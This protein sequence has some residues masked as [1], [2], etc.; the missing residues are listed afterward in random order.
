MIVYEAIQTS[1]NERDL[2]TNPIMIPT[3][4]CKVCDGGELKPASVYKTSKLLA[5]MGYLLMIPSALIL[6]FLTLI[7]IVGIVQNNAGGA[8]FGIGIAIV[9]GFI[10]LPVF[11][12]GFLLRMKR[13]VLKCNACGS[14]VNRE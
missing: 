4:K 10:C 13:S 9:I 1:H 6:A 3:I 12:V 2:Q 14:V 11:I 5:I 8:V 7:V